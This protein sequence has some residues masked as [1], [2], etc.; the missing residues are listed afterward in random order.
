[1]FVRLVAVLG[2]KC[3]LT[4][5]K[6]ELVEGCCPSLPLRFWF[7]QI[8]GDGNLDGYHMHVLLQ[9]VGT[10]ETRQIERRPLRTTVSL[11]KKLCLY[12]DKCGFA[13]A[14]ATDCRKTWT[15]SKTQTRLTTMKDKCFEARL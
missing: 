6:V 11:V 15:F 13:Q 5:T 4:D 8:D 9:R 2:G 14:Q 1:M 7:Q 10:D 3:I 12:I